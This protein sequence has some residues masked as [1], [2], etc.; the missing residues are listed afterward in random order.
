[1]RFDRCGVRMRNSCNCRRKSRR[2]AAFGEKNTASSRA[3]RT[4]TI[5]GVL[6]VR[7][8]PACQIIA[9]SAGWEERS[10]VDYRAGSPWM[11]FRAEP[12]RRDASRSR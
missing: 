4:S 3:I 1:M 5:A 9:G 2:T 10:F 12:A 6:R 7:S 11:F 8:N